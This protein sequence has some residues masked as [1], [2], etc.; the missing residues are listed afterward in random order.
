LF[1]LD[2]R[3]HRIAFDKWKLIP[4]IDDADSDDP[5]IA[6]AIHTFL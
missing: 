5:L 2:F 3:A 1:A 4:V 6:D